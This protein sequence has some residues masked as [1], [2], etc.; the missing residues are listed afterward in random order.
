MHGARDRYGPYRGGD[1]PLAPPFD[2]A[3][4][5]D[6]L[7]DHVLGGEGTE[8]AIRELMRRGLSGR[9]G[10]DQL[11]RQASRRQRRLRERGRLDGTL[12]DIEGLLED[13]V[14]TERR[15]LFPDPS[16]DARFRE[17]QLD[18]L[19]REVSR[20][21]REL[22]EY[23]WRSSDARE[24]YDQIRELL[25]TEVLSQQFSGIRNQLDADVSPH[26]MLTDLNDLLEK[27]AHGTDT[28]QDFD[29]FME[30]HG[31]HFPD[32]P[33]DLD[34]LLEDLARRAAAADRLLRSLPASSARRTH[35]LD[36]AEHAKFG[37][38]VGAGTTQRQS[39]GTSS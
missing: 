12:A 32:N 17:A 36:T 25:G 13:A 19:P 16:D 1:D 30:K 22:S 39:P 31:E 18:A 3:S 10:L 35:G 11:A 23:E 37:T 14:E 21:V 26:A 6:E 2:A 27:R 9:Q 24:Y 34:Q 15:A 8:S 29:S 38:A 33:G 20:A 28:Q 4:A 7:G 5:L